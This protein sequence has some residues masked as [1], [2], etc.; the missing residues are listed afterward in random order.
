MKII[1]RIHTDF[2]DKFGIPR[3]SGLVEELQGVIVFEPEYRNPDALRGIEGFSHLWL[4]WQFSRSIREKWQPMVRPPRLG[5]N[6]P[7]G[8]FAT[9]SPFRPNPIGL[10][11]VRLIGVEYTETRGAVLRVA[12]ADLMDGTPIY[13]IK[14]YLAYTDAHPDATGGFADPLRSHALEVTFPSELLARLPEDR[15]RAAIAVLENDPRPS[16]QNDP[17]REYGLYFAGFN[18]TFFV[19]GKA[20][21]VADVTPI[22]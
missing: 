18:I 19:D 9:R 21:R 3:Q 13:D 20:L 4:L 16:Y 10:S 11:S 22:E 17:E 6:T 2:P 12:G 14:P 5:G 15:R 7:M 1:A 8:V